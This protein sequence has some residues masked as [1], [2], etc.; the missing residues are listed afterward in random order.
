MSLNALLTKMS[1]E[2]KAKL[3][4]E[5]LQVMMTAR[6]QLEDSGLHLKALSAGEQMTDFVLRD[7]NNKE[8]SSRE[9]LAKGPL[10]ISWY[11]GIW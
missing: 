6:Q 11:R 5:V 7:A 2:S 10:L 9:A 4:P 1:Q 3:S 8:F